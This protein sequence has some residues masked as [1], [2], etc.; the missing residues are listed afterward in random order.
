MEDPFLVSS[1][2]DLHCH[3]LP[4][5]DD[6]ARSIDEGLQIITN[7]SAI[8]FKKIIATPHIRPGLFNNSPE[9]L[10]KSFLQ[11]L[12]HSQNRI[13]AELA[14]SAEHYFDESLFRDGIG[15]SCLAYPGKRAILLEFYDMSFPMALA[16]R[17]GAWSAS[18]ITPVI[19][20]PER[21]APVW[22]EPNVLEPLLD[23]GAVCLLDLAAVMG[24]YGSKPERTAKQLLERGFY[25]MACTDCHRPQDVE[26][27]AKSIEWIESEYS[28]A[29]VLQLLSHGPS[30]LLQTG[31]PVS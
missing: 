24:K 31:D 12:E 7:L 17:L 14:L 18:G 15:S 25:D 22:E 2:V 16:T 21:Y 11:F 3:F 6:G 4:G 5:I 30:K 27:M 13:S 20:H 8:G 19:A 1:F 9:I 29:E 23:A 28:K 26:I 10:R